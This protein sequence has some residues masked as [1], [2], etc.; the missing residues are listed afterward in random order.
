MGVNHLAPGA[1][2]RLFYIGGSAIRV[3]GGA[4]CVEVRVLPPSFFEFVFAGTVPGRVEVD[5]VEISVLG[6]FSP[7]VDPS[8]AIPGANADELGA[9][10]LLTS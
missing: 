6:A 2:V 3:K 4:F 10:V 8:G 1:S 7:D 5:R 9:R